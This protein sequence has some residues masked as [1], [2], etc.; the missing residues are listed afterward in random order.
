MSFEQANPGLLV[1][2]YYNIP[3]EEWSPMQTCQIWGFHGNDYKE[4]GCDSAGT[5]W[6][7]LTSEECATSIFRFDE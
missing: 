2:K 6:S 1:F 4:T 3:F 5:G 7:L